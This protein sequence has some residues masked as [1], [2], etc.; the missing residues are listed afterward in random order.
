MQTMWIQWM[1]THWWGGFLPLSQTNKL[2]IQRDG[3]HTCSFVLTILDCWTIE[4]HL[5]Y[6]VAIHALSQKFIHSM[7]RHVTHKRR[8]RKA[9]Y[10]VRLATLH[11]PMSD[12]LCNYFETNENIIFLKLLAYSSTCW[13]LQLLVPTHETLFRL[14]HL[15]I[16]ASRMKSTY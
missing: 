2:A 7:T 10:D 14:E 3:Q 1:T 16:K 12:W 6:F 15:H 5:E 4:K 9:N 11:G 13:W 8:E